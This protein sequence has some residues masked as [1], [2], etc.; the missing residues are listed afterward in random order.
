M[1]SRKKIYY[2]FQSDGFYFHQG[3]GVKGDSNFC[4]EEKH[5]E[6]NFCFQEKNQKVP[7][8]DQKETSPSDK[9]EIRSTRR[10]RLQEKPI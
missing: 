8:Y 9:D 6:A 4:Q 7:S 5:L 3:E 2:P 1:T 10:G